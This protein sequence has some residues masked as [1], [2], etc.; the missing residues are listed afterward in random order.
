MAEANEEAFKVDD[1]DKDQIEQSKD[2]NVFKSP[3]K[4]LK[5]THQVK[6]EALRRYQF[7]KEKQFAAEEA[8]LKQQRDQPCALSSEITDLE[9]F[10]AEEANLKQQRDH[11]RAL[12]SEITDLEQFA[13]E[14]ANLK[15]Q[16]NHP[17]T[18]SSEITDLEI[19]KSKQ[20][21]VR[22]VDIVLDSSVIE[23]EKPESSFE[24]SVTSTTH[25]EINLSTESHIAQSWSLG[26][27]QQFK[28]ANSALL[29]SSSSDGGSDKQSKDV[30]SHLD[31]KPVATFVTNSEE[32][33]VL[34]DSSTELTHTEGVISDV[35]NTKTYTAEEHTGS[36]TAEEK[37]VHS[38]NLLK[39][40]G[41]KND[42]SFDNATEG[43]A[44]EE[45]I[46]QDIGTGSNM[47]EEKNTICGPTSINVD[48]KDS[49]D[50]NVNMEL[51]AQND[52]I[53]IDKEK[54]QHVS[55]DVSNNNN[56]KDQKSA[57]DD[58]NISEKEIFNECGTENSPQD[59]LGFKQSET[60]EAEQED[61]NSESD[62]TINQEED[63]SLYKNDE[64]Y[65]ESY[66]TGD[67][68][69]DILTLYHSFGFECTKRSNLHLLSPDYVIFSTG[70][71][72]Q[73]LNLKTKK[74]VNIRSTSGRGIGAIAVH[75]NRQ[76]FAV[77][78][79][80]IKPDIIIYENPSLKIYRI[81]REGT[82]EAYANLDF[83][84]SGE[85][86][87]SVGSA[88]DYM[89]TIWDWNEEQIILRSKA[90]SQDVYKVAF[91]P[92]DE[93]HLCSSGTGHIK[94]WMMAN[95]F[96]GLKLQGELGRFG[97]TEL[98][99]ISGFVELPDGKVLSGSE[100]GN[101]LLWD[102]GLIK[103]EITRKGKK[104]CHNGNIEQ[105]FLDEGE[106][107]TVGFDG[108]V[109]VWD[110]ESV[111]T[112]DAV[113]ESKL[114]E[115]EPMSEL[116]VGNEV[117]LLSMVK[118]V[119]DEESTIWYAQDAS[120]GI[121]KLDLSFSHTSQ[122]PDKLFSYHSGNVSTVALSPISHFA[123]TTGQDGTVRLFDFLSKIPLCNKKFNFSGCSLLWMPK[124]V[125]STCSSILVGFADG[126]VR[127]LSIAKNTQKSGRKK[128]NISN[129]TLHL[130]QVFKPHIKPVTCMAIDGT[131]KILATGSTD[132]TVFFFSMEKTI[133][134]IGFV[135]TAAEVVSIQWSTIKMGNKL[136][137]A[138]RNGSI[139]EF[140]QPS[141]GK[142]DTTK[143]FQ[144]PLQ[145]LL[146][147]EYQFKSIKDELLK[148]EEDVR[149]AR[150]EAERIRIRDEERARRKAQGIEEE[151]EEEEEEEVKDDDDDDDAPPVKHPQGDVLKAF[152]RGNT[153]KFVLTMDG[154]DAGYLYECSFENE[155]ESSVRA[156]KIPD[157]NDVPVTSLHFSKDGSYLA[158][159]LKDGALRVHSM[160]S[161]TLENLTSY[162]YTNAH[163]N[164]YGSVSDIEISFDS[165]FLISVG[166][167][168]NIF[169]FSFMD[170]A[171]LK[172]ALAQLK[173]NI[174]AKDV[175]TKPADDIDDPK[176]YSIELEK[177][178][179]EHDRMV[180]LAEEKKQQVKNTIGKLRRQFRKL[181]TRNEELPSYLQLPTSDFIIDP[182]MKVDLEVEREE[183][184]ELVKKET[185]YE[186]ERHRIALMK[187]QKR[188]KESVECDRIVLYAFG[189]EHSVSS[190]R[191]SKLTEEFFSLV[192]DNKRRMTLRE[193]GDI[194]S[195]QPRRTS[196][197]VAGKI[198]GLRK[199][200]Q[201][202]K[203]EGKEDGINAA[204]Q[205]TTQTQKLEGKIAKVIEKVEERKLK[206]LNRQK[207]WA[208]LYKNKPDENYED[209]KDI[210]AIKFAAL[211]IGD[212]KLKTAS[213]YVVPEAQRVNA[214]KKR[215]Q[216]F[217]L[218][219][220]VHDL[221][222]NFNDR[223]LKLRDRKIATIQQIKDLTEELEVVQSHLPE[224]NHKLVPDVPSMKPDELPEKNLEYTTETLMK[225]RTDVLGL[226]PL[227]ADG[228]A[229]NVGT[230]ENQSSKTVSNARTVTNPRLR[231]TSIVSNF[232]SIPQSDSSIQSETPDII[233]EEVQHEGESPL[234]VAI[235]KEEMIRLTHQRDELLK[236]ISGK[237]NSFDAELRLLRHDKI[238]L[239][240]K[241][242]NA[243][244]KEITLFEELIL[245]KDF[246][247]REEQLRQ[248][249]VSKFQE[250]EEME[251]KFD[252]SEE[253]LTL[254][255]E[256]LDHLLQR[257]KTLFTT[258][259]NTIGDN[260]KFEG[261]LTK[262]FKK[263]IKR[264]KKKTTDGGQSDE[265]SSEEESDD[266]YDSDE[267]GD[268][269]E[270]DEL[271]DS[272]CPTGCDQVIF[273]QICQLRERKLDLEEMIVDAKKAGDSTKKEVDALSKKVKI[274]TSALKN[275]AS[276]L[277]AFQREKQQKLNELNV[278]VT[279]KLD[280]IQY[281]VNNIIPHDLSKCLVFERSFLDR[282][283]KRIKELEK[284]KLKQKQLYRERRQQ[285][286]QMIRDKKTMDTKIKE[287]EDKVQQI[288]MLKFGRL[289]DLEK[290]ETVSVN[291]VA[292]ELKE[293]LRDQEKRNAKDIAGWDK[294]IDG[295]Q[296]ELTKLIR[297]NT[298]RLDTYT[299]FHQEK[300]QLEHQLD[301]RQKN[302]GG[303]F[304][305][306]RKTDLEEQQR[307]VQLVQLQS[308]EIDALKNEIS[309]LSRKG[310]HIMPP[311][312]PS[313]RRPPRENA[314]Q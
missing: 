24:E 55:A 106:L 103:V 49:V 121:W 243:E 285:H 251:D 284:E 91:S 296:T 225:F 114:F 122:S 171:K 146:S 69:P 201:G 293:K 198:A 277:E 28:D 89:M 137:V 150:E 238:H 229:S 223:L 71:Y 210:D 46:Y 313:A 178:K 96:T 14:E 244:L 261:F 217:D 136:L 90:F 94:F 226:Q 311:P 44:A 258:F 30:H 205:P 310:G 299:I 119:D 204:A 53:V 29:D 50:S 283:Q 102:G 272:V 84:P 70:N 188:F 113:D 128:H 249:V 99:D 264:A 295:L 165:K 58:A 302:L 65:S 8:N 127:H 161:C 239:D 174:N 27:P 307:L 52:G 183:K 45:K 22:N 34:N 85:K 197:K 290:L 297:E 232:S 2:Q 189:T 314:T 21:D 289:V 18:L 41:N 207:E 37:L 132:E 9:Q 76:Y 105:F 194:L 213:D 237:L 306:N 202:E 100:W 267:E 131:G 259:S 155:N 124:I 312:G 110:F 247:K 81:L 298:K 294:K 86:L 170:E 95:T 1:K 222:K 280:Q 73:I 4:F 291:R 5:V 231:S 117:K 172:A 252:E 196:W 142:F 292:E 240:T 219:V 269:D 309:V 300:K 141:S 305:G 154:W 63:D 168:G 20:D 112:A 151:D 7:P 241:L 304:R 301:S 107:I 286:V 303:E 39:S 212:F 16:R 242:K 263:K 134:P 271:D 23:D 25:P 43:Y 273:D 12:S 181:K 158:F 77:A 48:G 13:A 166:N 83:S 145:G 208:E 274:V 187:L 108:F 144:L 270:D 211:T 167:D 75:P 169:V 80:G 40:I 257:E 130:T 133:R 279:L 64:Q 173:T 179:A 191:A 31:D 126:V 51:A 115:L 47:D 98:S 135:E 175:D 60:D 266:D 215:A 148:A 11:P 116:K 56:K 288:Q 275:A 162:W 66:S 139:Q 129:V 203:D 156:I 180:R 3:S 143:S 104:N 61:M 138:C 101:M 109:K 164:D 195:G 256:E 234:E 125:D 87:A 78:E 221:K 214:E 255:K 147:K 82:E 260:N 35:E 74:Q 224:T 10:A 17:S 88:P 245:L 159:G 149:K 26:S 62:K 209:P 228:V 32:K 236:D 42:K 176:H 118:S 57:N 36:I 72:F 111:D 92:E 278:V 253:L 192:A 218:E 262:V 68:P 254:K 123:A 190:Y 38:A 250:K 79:K 54:G 282:L 193:T 287:L 157:I 152:Y 185:A 230:V 15:Q 153:G 67:V 233:D 308:Q 220:K 281:V 59:K 182:Q 227:Q 276:D 246:E 120:G 248:K 33:A 160:A 93:G 235:E 206:R 163:D 199:A 6:A 177:Q 186:S 216:L 200:S 184:I 19:P 268:S 140:L 97:T 265:E